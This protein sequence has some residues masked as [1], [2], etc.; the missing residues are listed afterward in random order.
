MTKQD[1]K[2]EMIKTRFINLDI[3]NLNLLHFLK[4]KINKKKSIRDVNIY[5]LNIK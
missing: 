4:C 1:R 3:F 2:T 5:Q